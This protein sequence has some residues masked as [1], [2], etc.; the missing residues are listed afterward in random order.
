MI[1][2]ERRYQGQEVTEEYEFALDSVWEVSIDFFFF[3]NCIFKLFILLFVFSHQ[4]PREKLVFDQ[5]LGN[6]AFGQVV[7]ARAEGVLRPG[8]VTKVAVKMLKGIFIY[9]SNDS[10][11]KFF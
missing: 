8:E 11:F 10:Q 4:F 7:L 1:T 3:I 2:I 6:G 5:T 9:F